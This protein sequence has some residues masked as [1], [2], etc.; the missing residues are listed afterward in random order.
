MVEYSYWFDAGP[1]VYQAFPFGRLIAPTDEEL[2]VLMI[3]N[4]ILSLRYSSPLK[5]P[6]GKVSY[7]VTLSNPYN[8][9]IL[10]SQA[11]NAVKRGLANCE[12]HQVPFERIAGE[13]W[14]LQ[15]D[16]LERQGRLNSMSENQWKKLCLSAVGLDGFEAWSAIID[17]ELAASLI[18]CQDD[19]I[20]YVPY[21]FSLRKY[22]G[23]YVNN[24]LFYSVS[25]NLLARQGINGIFFTVQ[26]L[27]APV[28]V[29]D[30]KFRMG[31]SAKAVRQRVV[32][33][34]VL[35]P[36]IT[37]F[38]HGV[39]TSLLKRYPEN[40][41][42]AK[43]EGMIRFYLDGKLDIDQQDWPSCIKQFKTEVGEEEKSDT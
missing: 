32:F 14:N 17:G 40:T 29:D 33:N 15:R 9:E 25:C 3:K 34:P 18:I 21:A 13:G 5:A 36:F 39:V 41:L 38:T 1:M 20:F 23:L 6:L 28:S 42:L 4:R 8:L 2:N 31:F 7:H 27:D 19:D 10:R 16:T 43:T 11:R 30:F 26:S 12:I 22:L 37:K 24:A 35:R